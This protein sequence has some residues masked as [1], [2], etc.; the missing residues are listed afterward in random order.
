MSN[1]KLNLLNLMHRFREIFKRL[2][3]FERTKKKM[4]YYDYMAAYVSIYLDISVELEIKVQNSKLTNINYD[5]LSEQELCTNTFYLL[6]NFTELRKLQ[7]K[8]NFIFFL[9]DSCV[10]YV[11]NALLQLKN[12]EN[13]KLNFL[14]PIVQ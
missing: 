1:F 6:G 2:N 14:F 9:L 4:S 7:H 13:S 11:C 5:H 3:C 10:Y 8:K 12:F